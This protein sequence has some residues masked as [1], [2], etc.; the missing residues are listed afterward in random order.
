MSCAGGLVLNAGSEPQVAI[1]IPSYKQFEKTLKPCLESIFE[2]RTQISFVVIVVDN[3]SDNSTK[4]FIKSAAEQNPG[5]IIPIFFS[6]NRGYGAANNAGFKAVEAPYYVLLNSDTRVSDN[7]LDRLIEF[8]QNHPEAGLSGPVT[9]SSGN[10]Q[11]IPIQDEDPQK[12]FARGKAWAE[13]SLIDDYHWTDRLGFFCVALRR[14]VIDRIGLF[15]ED[16]GIALFED[17]DFCIR[18]AQSGFR[19][20]W[21]ETAFVYHKGSL[22]LLE[23]GSQIV[24]DLWK[25]NLEVF[26][27]KHGMRWKSAWDATRIAK[28]IREDLDRFCSGES[29]AQIIR[30]ANMRL[31]AMQNEESFSASTRRESSQNEA[32]LKNRLRRLEAS[33]LMLEEE[34]PGLSRRIHSADA[35]LNI[36]ECVRDS[37]G[38]LKKETEYILFGCGSYGKIVLNVLRENGYRLTRCFDNRSDMWGTDFKGLKVEQP[39]YSKD[40]QVLIATQYVEEV[41]EQLLDLGY[42][43]CRLISFDSGPLGPSLEWRA[44]EAIDAL[45]Y[46]QRNGI[47]ILLRRFFSWNNFLN[48]RPQQMAKALGQA[49]VT[50]FYTGTA[51]DRIAG[52]ANMGMGCF[53]TQY[54]ELFEEWPGPRIY[55]YYSTDFGISERQVK[56]QLEAGHQVLYEYV[57]A[58]S[59]EIT[60]SV[61]DRFRQLHRQI[62]EDERVKVV[63][64]AEQLIEDVK[65][66]RNVN[67]R[68]I[69]NGVD[70]PH[71][72]RSFDRKE[73]PPEIAKII[74][75]GGPTICYYGALATWIDYSLLSELAKAR[76]DINIILIG[77]DYDGSIHGS[78]LKHLKNIHILPPVSYGDL[79][80]YVSQVDF[81]MIPF[82][83][84][85]VT[86]CTSPIKLFEYMA[87]EKPI[88]A[89]AMRECRKYKSVLIAES[90][91]DFVQ[92]IKMAEKLR[93]DKEYRG[94]LKREAEENSWS[95]KAGELLKFLGCKNERGPGNG[96]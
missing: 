36:E 25:K 40:E 44:R 7:W 69:T 37:I 66:H 13:E 96:H 11:K 91:D 56:R 33:I 42:S 80:R 22:S 68:L 54:P 87:M 67:Y 61:P 16:Y 15:D 24:D 84:N 90:H 41:R 57:D 45:P 73:T 71:F 82:Q 9:N 48:Q 32:A 63:A 1:I 23:L 39:I 38:S 17:D 74:A 58:I 31:E 92:K 53:V 76:R 20:A 77:V 12:I 18:A 89:T 6:N 35:R 86:H 28:V 52:I 46:A 81:F 30:R 85:E 34:E 47:G 60:G 51:S 65:R 75:S 83:L 95:S 49:G 93:N 55:H 79:P 72:R 62:L 10:E 21:M 27:A 70:L 19:L 50:Y 26:E 29:D 14:E 43:H 64:T 94:L 4:E 5:K 8:L 3:G 78:D 2:A 59:D 88:I